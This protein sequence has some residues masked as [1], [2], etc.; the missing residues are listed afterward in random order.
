M[1]QFNNS[2]SKYNNKTKFCEQFTREGTCYYSERC[3]FAHSLNE[4]VIF[5]CKFGGNCKKVHRRNGGDYVNK[6]DQMCTYLHPLSDSI[7]ERK[8]DC[9]KRN[10]IQVPK[11]RQC[12]PQNTLENFPS[13]PVFQ[14]QAVPV[15]HVPEKQ[16]VV[17]RKQS[18][19]PPPP[20]MKWGVSQIFK[21]ELP[22]PEAPKKVQEVPAKKVQ[23][24]PKE[25]PKTEVKKQS[26]SKKVSFVEVPK[27]VE[28]QVPQPPQM[29]N[30]P[31]QKLQTPKECKLKFENSESFLE[32]LDSMLSEG[33]D[34]FDVEY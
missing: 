7:Y 16:V 34:T 4:L 3:H 5:P 1:S 2:G 15:Q 8:E 31:P 20:P 14:R 22:K 25:V 27:I 33:Y 24:L 23:E 9:L 18:T 11:P 32:K 28:E 13:Q 17:E 29:T 10:G 21:P 26:P 30:V 6:K 19:L 12:V